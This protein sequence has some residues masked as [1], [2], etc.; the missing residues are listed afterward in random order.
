MLADD[1][2][3][4]VALVSVDPEVERATNDYTELLVFIVLVEE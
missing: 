2:S 1:L 4:L 3:L